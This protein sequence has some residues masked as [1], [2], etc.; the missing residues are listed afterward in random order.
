M[1]YTANSGVQRSK[2]NFKNFIIAA[3]VYMLLIWG[4]TLGILI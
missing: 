1:V 3:T 2:L 4:L